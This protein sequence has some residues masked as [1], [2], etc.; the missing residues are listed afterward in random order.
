LGIVTGDVTFILVAILG[1]SVLADRMGGLF[2]L[3][4]YAGGI[5]LVGLGVV[6]WRSAPRAVDDQQHQAPSRTSSF[7]TGLLITLGDQKAILF[8]LGFLPAFVDL[9]KVSYLDT[10]VI[11]AAAVAAVGGVKLVYAGLADR[12][13]QWLDGATRW[14]NAVAAGL[15]IAV[16]V[17]LVAKA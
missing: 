1:L 3:V 4:K 7:L 8:Y 10:G 11:V 12:A 15:M 17:F 14:I 13:G 5:Y 16:G 2:V 9:S 6:L